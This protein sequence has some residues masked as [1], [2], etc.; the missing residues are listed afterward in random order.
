MW[1]AAAAHA[2]GCRGT[3]PIA[4]C[5]QACWGCVGRRSW[6]SASLPAFP[7]AVHKPVAGHPAQSG[8]P[9][10]VCPELFVSRESFFSFELQ[11]GQKEY[12]NA[13]LELVMLSW[14]LCS[15][16]AF[17]SGKSN[18]KAVRWGLFKAI[19]TSAD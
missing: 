17:A 6:G 3:G 8:E 18:I 15:G 12:E 7:G 4:I 10:V 1:A 9:A 2:A 16:G 5:A 11:G 19:R 13:Q 14:S